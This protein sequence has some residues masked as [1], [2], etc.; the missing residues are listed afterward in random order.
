VVTIKEVGDF[1]QK[2]GIHEGWMGM[3]IA[4]TLDLIEQPLACSAGHHGKNYS[5]SSKQGL[6]RPSKNIVFAENMVFVYNTV[7]FCVNEHVV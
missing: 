4:I 5:A 3:N 6:N 1:L 2:H 7:F